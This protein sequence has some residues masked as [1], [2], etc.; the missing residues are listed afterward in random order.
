[1]TPLKGI[2]VLDMSRAIAGPLCSQILADLGAE[3]IKV[4]SPGLGDETRGWPPFKAEQ[5]GAVF[6][7]VNRNKRSIVIDLKAPEGRALLHRM[8]LQADVAIE[9]FN[10]GVAERLGIDAATL[11]GLND[12]LVHC[13]ISGFGRT[14]PLSTAPGYDVVLQAFCGI[15]GL[16]GEEG[17]GHIRSPISPI[18][19][20][21]SSH[22]AIGIMAALMERAQ[23][24]KG[25][26]VQASLYDTAMA[27]QRYNL[28]MYWIDGKLQP[29]CGSGHE[30]LCP[31]QAFEASDGPILIGVANDKLWRKFCAIAGLGDMADHPKY[32]NNA[33]RSRHRAE[34]VSRVQNVVATQ[35]VDHWYARLAEAGI[36]C[37]PINRLDQLLDHPHTRATGIVV[38]Y[39]H[40][41]VGA[42]KGVAQPFILNGQPRK[43]GTPPPLHGEHTQE[44]L[45]EFGLTA[46]EIEA[47]A[48]A[49]VT[50]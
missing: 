7:S 28:Q 23:T 3:V 1:M 8:A 34:V 5:M 13:S 33:G 15:M 17:G 44:I 42:I 6:L 21:T 18:D 41:Q 46:A 38:D 29:R 49:N 4:E 43:G 9:S 35:T 20:M 16:T 24:G 27:F 36:P 10:T 2:K 39:E 48:V 40:D 26:T 47:L 32:R 37:S 45:E 31:Y 11:C 50:V 25:G 12:R 14:G 30:S 19:Q 22:A